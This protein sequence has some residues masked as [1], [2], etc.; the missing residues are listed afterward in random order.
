MSQDYYTDNMRNQTNEFNI[1]LVGIIK[2]IIQTIIFS[3]IAR[4]FYTI[5]KLA[6][7]SYPKI[8]IR[9]ALYGC[10]ITFILA[11]FFDGCAF[12]VGIIVLLSFI[13][14]IGESPFICGTPSVDK[15]VKE[16]RTLDHI[17]KCN[18]FM[19]PVSIAVLILGQ[20]WDSFLPIKILIFGYGVYLLFL[21]VAVEIIGIEGGK[22]VSASSASDQNIAA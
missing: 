21:A 18:V 2:F 11:N 20:F 1:D 5:A 17:L 3:I 10:G 15:D 19:F 14:S 12:A 16:C 13:Y 4:G 8:G 22:M 9:I 7:Y 6:F